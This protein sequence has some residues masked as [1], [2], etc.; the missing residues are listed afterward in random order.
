MLRDI[1]K[2]CYELFHHRI[3]PDHEYS[4]LCSLH[5]SFGGIGPEHHNCL[6]CNFADVTVWIDR[7]LSRHGAFED[8]AEVFTFYLL[9]LYLFVERANI[10]FD[11]IKLP[12]E[13]RHRHFAVFK[14]VHK[15][16]NFIKHPNSFVL[17]H[18]PTHSFVG[19]PTFNRAAFAVVIDQEFVNEH[20]SAPVHNKKL[21][22]ALENKKNVAVLYPQPVVLTASFCD[23]ADHFIAVVRDNAVYREILASRSTYQNYFVP[24]PAET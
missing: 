15:W 2:Q 7:F 10:I 13:Y 3:C 19:D 8:L 4:S 21:W 14:D 16:A 9:R 18:H 12:E 23:A 20:Y 5:D 17:V 1:F 11:V 22:D 6:G 24:S